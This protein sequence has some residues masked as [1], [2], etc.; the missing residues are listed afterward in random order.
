[1]GLGSV[2]PSR[3]WPGAGGPDE[4]ERRA[5]RKSAIHLMAPGRRGTLHPAPREPLA[6]RKAAARP[7]RGKVRLQSGSRRPGRASPCSCEGVV[8]PPPPPKKHLT[9]PLA[10]RPSTHPSWTKPLPAEGPGEVRDSPPPPSPPQA[11]P[12]TEGSGAVGPTGGRAAP[13]TRGSKV[14]FCHLGAKGRPG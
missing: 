8:V 13:T 12:P 4:E 11:T 6:G 10:F 1:M 7:S 2:P 14:L 5:R 9:P 3:R